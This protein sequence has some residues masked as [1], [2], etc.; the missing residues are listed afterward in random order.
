MQE[1]WRGQQPPD[2]PIFKSFTRPSRQTARFLDSLSP[3]E[4]F[5]NEAKEFSAKVPIKLI[6]ANQL[7]RMMFESKTIGREMMT[8]TDSM[9]RKCCAIV[10]HRLR[11]P[12]PLTCPNGHVVE[13]TLNIDRLLASS[14]GLSPVCIKCGTP[15]RLI[16]GKRGPFWGCS[17]YP[18][19]RSTRNYGPSGRAK[20][21]R[22]IRR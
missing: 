6:D 14:T 2:D 12:E 11:T 4:Q 22:R 8:H 5:T 10:R 9:C 3:R 13:P 17:R 16:N 18:E 20:T 19:C 7:V 21:S 15:M 1:I